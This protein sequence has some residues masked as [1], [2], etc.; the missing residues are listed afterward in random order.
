MDI[1]LAAA[2]VPLAAVRLVDEGV[3]SAFGPV[4][5]VRRS[6]RAAASHSID[7]LRSEFEPNRQ[8]LP[9]YLHAEGEFAVGWRGAIALLLLSF[10]DT[11]V[12]LF[13]SHRRGVTHSLGRSSPEAV[14]SASFAAE[15][16]E[17]AIA[18][19]FSYQPRQMWDFFI[20]STHNLAFTISLSQRPKEAILSKAA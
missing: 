5:Q 4:E 9:I 16:G 3:G 8:G 20:L 12:G 6:Q 7:S 2:S 15:Q 11:V 14:E 1:S 18:T 19:K 13:Q 10:A 17:D